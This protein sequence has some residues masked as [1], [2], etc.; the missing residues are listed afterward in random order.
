MREIK[1]KAW[2]KQ[3]KVWTNWKCYDNM[4]YF[5][6][7]YIGTWLRDDRFERFLLIQYTGLN[8]KHDKEI[9]EGDVVTA[10]WYDYDEPSST[11]TGVIEFSEGWMAYW[12]ADYEGKV[13]SEINGKGAYAWDIEVIGNIHDNPELVDECGG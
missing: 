3:K 6:D 5:M 2:D 13:F 7:K 9:Y 10:N 8:D 1:F 4:F 11:I 12:I